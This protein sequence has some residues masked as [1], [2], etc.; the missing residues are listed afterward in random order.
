MRTLRAITG[1][2]SSENSKL[3]V[4]GE[5]VVFFTSPSSVRR[6][7]LKKG[8]RLALEKNISFKFIKLEIK[9]NN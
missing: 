8:L 7:P 5:P 9:D 4:D 3:E 2:A 1:C 6:P